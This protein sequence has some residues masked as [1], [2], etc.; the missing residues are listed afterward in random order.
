LNTKSVQYCVGLAEE[1]ATIVVLL[2]VVLP[3]VVIALI[4]AINHRK[5][6]YC[7]NC[8]RHTLQIV[9][10]DRTFTGKY[11]NEVNMCCAPMRTKT[12]ILQ[13]KKFYKCYSCG[14]ETTKEDFEN[15]KEVDAF[16]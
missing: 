6:K 10:E 2:I 5:Q 1:I 14:Y 8:G 15:G 12:E 13:L 9:K 11:K 16:E 3:A 7:P 4:I